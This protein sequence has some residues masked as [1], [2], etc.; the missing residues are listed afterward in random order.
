MEKRSEQILVE[1]ETCDL[2]VERDVRWRHEKKNYPEAHAFNGRFT[3]NKR[4]RRT[5]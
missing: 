5:P 4:L 1:E 3:G 2:L